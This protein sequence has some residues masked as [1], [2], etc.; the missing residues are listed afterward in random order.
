MRMNNFDEKYDVLIIGGGIVGLM[1]AYH[2]LKL[3]GKNVIVVEKGYLGS[4][5]TGR[6]GGGIREQWGSPENIILAKKSIDLWERLPE[7]LEADIHFRQGGYLILAF[8]EE[9]AEMLKNNVKIQ[10][11][12]G[13]NSRI[14]TPEEAKEI[15]P[16]LNTSIIVMA[17]FNKRD[18]KA[19]PFKTL[20]ALKQKIEEMGGKVLTHTEVTGFN[21]KGKKIE[22]AITNRGKIKADLYVNASGTWSKM[23]GEMIGE[24]IPIEPYRHEIMVTERLGHLFDPMVISFSKGIYFQQMPKGEIIGGIG[25]PE[26]KPGF[27]DKPT[28]W[29]PYH[30]AKTLIEIAPALRHV[31]MLRHWTGYYEVTPDAKPIID[32]S[33]SV[34]N[35]IHVAG[36][37]GHGFMVAPMSGLLVAEMLLGKE[38]SIDIKPYSIER[39]E[40][41]EITKEVG[42]VG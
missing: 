28:A 37:S 5:S 39:F 35:L 26:E 9:E 31:R 19:D 38:P 11:E 25:N 2:Y 34:E 27:Y 24:N 3:G 10:H 8:S 32:W 17:T 7:E 13:V 4:G 16:I 36:F 33:K 29:F 30:F 1:T 14:L 20:F 21:I 22:Y 6:C 12:Y 15:V 42:V 40:K 41:G 23:I 18:A